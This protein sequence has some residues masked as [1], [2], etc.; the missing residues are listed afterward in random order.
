MTVFCV[1]VIDV[2]LYN[3]FVYFD[4]YIILERTKNGS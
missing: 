1:N 2:G 4:N 3:G